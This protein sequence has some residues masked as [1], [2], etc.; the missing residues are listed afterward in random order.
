MPLHQPI[1]VVRLVQDQVLAEGANGLDRPIA[2]HLVDQRDRLPVAAQQLAGRR[3]RPDARHQFILLAADHASSLYRPNAFIAGRSLNENST[4][5]PRAP[6][7][8]FVHD[9]TQKM[10]FS[11]HSKRLPP[12]SDQPRPLATW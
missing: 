11:S 2:L 7:R 8:Y 10:S 6:W 12:I 5:S 4:A 9:G 1:T 3:S